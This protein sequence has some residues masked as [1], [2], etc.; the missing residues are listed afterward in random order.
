MNPTLNPAIQDLDTVAL[1][2]DIPDQG[3]RQGNMGAVVHCYADGAAFEV[4]F[5]NLEGQTT[6]LLT[7]TPSDIQPIYPYSTHSLPMASESKVTMNFHGSVHGVAGNVEG[8]QIVN[9]PQPAQ[10]ETITEILQIFQQLQHQHPTATATEAADIIEAEFTEI[11][12]QQP[13][14]WKA[15]RQQLL[16]R[17]RWLD[18]GKAA[19]NET[20]KHYAENSVVCKAGL[21]FLDAFSKDAAP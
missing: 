12:A 5:V 2:H 7:L 10:Q 21:A 17:E 11:Q 15:F 1:T 6:A 20:A 16:N 18:G 14:K 19:L 9:A 13:G 3:L 8:D 4:E